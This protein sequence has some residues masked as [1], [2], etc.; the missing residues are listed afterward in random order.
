VNASIGHFYRRPTLSRPFWRR[1][2]NRVTIEA[3]RARATSVSARHLC[4][5]LA[6]RSNAMNTMG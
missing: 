4:K 3:S 1:R 5:S 6:G 2:A